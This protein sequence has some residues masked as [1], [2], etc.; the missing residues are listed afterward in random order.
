MKL[1]VYYKLWNSQIWGE[2]L[3]TLWIFKEKNEENSYQLQSILK[4][5]EIN[6]IDVY[7]SAK[8]YGINQSYCV[9][10]KS[11]SHGYRPNIHLVIKYWNL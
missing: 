9:T 2:N 1:Y 7:Y 3:K 11:T 10:L 5:Y 6:T 4:K 8:H